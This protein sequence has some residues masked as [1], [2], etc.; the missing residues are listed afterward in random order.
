MLRVI[1]RLIA[2]ALLVGTLMFASAG[3]L[4]WRRA[5]VLLVVL[6]FVRLMGAY[7]VHRVNPV[8][9]EDRARL[10]LH[11]DQ[12]WSDRLLVIAVLSTGFVGVP[13]VAAFD[14]FRWHALPQP[15]PLLAGIGLALFVFG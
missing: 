12:S 15:T 4:A 2:D 14:A 13:I 9:L 7:I 3:T 11:R 10:P 6:L 8:L 1:A 5:W